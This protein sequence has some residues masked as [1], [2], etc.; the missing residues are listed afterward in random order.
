MLF[1]LTLHVETSLMIQKSLY[2]ITLALLPFFLFAQRD[3]AI[4]DFIVKE[5]LIK[6]GKLAVIATDAEENP[7]ETVSGTYQFTINGFRHALKFNDGVAVMPNAIETSAFVFLKHHNQAGS[8]GRLY[9][10]LKTGDGLNP[11]PINW[12]YLIL[13]PAI[14]LLI[15]YVFKR[16]MILALVVLVGLFIFYYNKGLDLENFFETIVHGIKDVSG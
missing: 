13:V 5:H 16:I 10:V 15:A 1:L 9:Y 7:I 11:I 2:L 8:H 3:H 14:I 12:Y 4:P 6:N